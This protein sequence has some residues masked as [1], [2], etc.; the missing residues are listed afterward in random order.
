MKLNE[1]RSTIDISGIAVLRWLRNCGRLRGSL[2]PRLP[3]PD[4][5]KGRCVCADLP[6]SLCVWQGDAL[7]QHAYS[8]MK[9]RRTRA[10]CICI[11]HCRGITNRGVPVCLHPRKHMFVPRQT[12]DACVAASS[13]SQAARPLPICPCSP[14]SSFEGH[15]H[16]C[17]AN[18][19]ASSSR[20]SL[21]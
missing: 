5:Q 7:A 8:S 20:R 2:R 13:S 15:A 18:G 4:P 1:E 6:P 12:S 14:C 17:H 21:M 9:A 11:W 10:S 19:F 16:V 3:H